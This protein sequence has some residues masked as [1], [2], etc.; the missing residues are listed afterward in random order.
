VSSGERWIQ[1]AALI[2][3][4][5]VAW[6]AYRSA[7]RAN[8]ITS[9]GADRTKLT[10]DLQEEVS[11]LRVVVGETRQEADALRFRMRALNDYLDL[12]IAKMRREGI[13]PPPVPAMARHPWEGL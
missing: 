7:T 3:P 5:V 1:A 11:A 4:I 6:F 10:D 12:C 9:D 8:K 13:E 2:V